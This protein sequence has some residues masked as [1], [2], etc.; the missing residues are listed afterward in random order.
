[1]KIAGADRRPGVVDE[2]DLAVDVDVVAAAPWVRPCDPD[3]SEICV[4]TQRVHPLKESAASGIPARG[5][6]VVFRF[7]GNKHDNVDAAP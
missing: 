1:M 6:D 5:A 4:A 7:G 3:E 2:H